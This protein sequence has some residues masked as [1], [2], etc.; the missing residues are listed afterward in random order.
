M[1]EGD[2][3]AR[4]VPGGPEETAELGRALNALAD[5]IHELV[6]EEREQVAD[7]NL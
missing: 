5:R 6:E 4:A 1:R 2:G 7:L 3:A